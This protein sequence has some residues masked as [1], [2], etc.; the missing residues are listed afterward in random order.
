LQSDRFDADFLSSA[1]AGQAAF[2]HAVA[3]TAE[4]LVGNY[5]DLDRCYAGGSP[6]QVAAEVAA[7]DVCPEEGLGIDRTMA[8]V[9]DLILRQSVLV[10]DPTCLGHLHCPP[11]IP[12]IA[13]EMVISATNQSMDSWDQA[14][15]ATY[16]EQHVVDWIGRLFGLGDAADGIF[17]SGGTQSNFM[18]LLLAR[19]LI[20]N[21]HGWN[22]RQFGMPAEAF[23]LRILCSDAAHFSIQ[24]SAAI[25]G[26]G[27]A[28]V[29]GIP[30]DNGRR[31]DPVALADTIALLKADGLIP[32]MVVATA[33]TTDFGSIDP[34]NAIADIC[35]AEQLWLHVDAAYGGALAVSKRLAPLLAGIGRADSITVDFH[36]LFYMPI[37]C[38]TFLVRRRS[39]FDAISLH[40]DYLN[41]EENVEEGVLDLV[42]KSIQTTRRFDGL[43]PFMTFQSLGR[44]RLASMI[45]ATIDLSQDIARMIEADP[46]LR[47]AVWPVI[48]ALVFRFEAEDHDPDAVDA[49]NREIRRS[50]LADGKAL[51]AGTKVDGRSWLKLTVLNPRT[52]NEHMR[53][54]LNDVTEAGRA[55]LA[56]LP[57]KTG[58]LGQPA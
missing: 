12:A 51:L 52:T 25:L 41:P 30:T 31:M 26:M 22:I 39:D 9:A 23:K 54:I 48:N 27:E 33:G 11:L 35:A 50:L 38:S 5:A 6:Q 20:G 58:A 24:Q 43:K 21:R 36:K 14:P 1:P 57:L 16:L 47:L 34:L 56:R 40:A 28:S 8:T 3:I 29:I 17:T 42:T 4:A 45:E 37:S 32:F 49:I 53:A 13:A 44:R 2:R 46:A 55:M 15:A 10:A 18:A 19:N 7:I